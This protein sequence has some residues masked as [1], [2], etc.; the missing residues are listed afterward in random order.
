MAPDTLGDSWS[1]A[2]TIAHDQLTSAEDGFQLRP[3]RED[4]SKHGNLEPTTNNTHSDK[5][6]ARTNQQSNQTKEPKRPALLVPW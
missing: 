2:R 5:V 4:H 1:K 6:H 3:L